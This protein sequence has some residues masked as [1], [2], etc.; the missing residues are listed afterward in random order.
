[1]EVNIF[2]PN[3]VQ[4]QQVASLQNMA[5]QQNALRAQLYQQASADWV[6][7]NVRNRDLGLAIAPLPTPPKKI[8]VTDDGQWT[9]TPF[10]T[11]QPPVLPPLA[12]QLPSGSLRPSGPIPPDRTDQLIGM[13]QVVNAKLDALLAR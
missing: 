8:V 1:M 5:A 7:T 13:L 11:L 12:A 4:K 10:D 6:T 3:Y 9:E 2:D